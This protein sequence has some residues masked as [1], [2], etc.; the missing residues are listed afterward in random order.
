MFKA[1]L[2]EA[3]GHQF[4][5]ARLFGSKARGDSRRDS[6]IDVAVIT[7]ARDWRVSNI[8]YGIAT[9]ILLDQG[10]ALSPK[11]LNEQQYRHLK[12]AKAA[13]AVNIA[14]EGIAL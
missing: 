10:I 4:I 7:S 6:D 3:L 13:F 2:V 8:V 5:E 12:R 11:V 14:K 1:A 9:D